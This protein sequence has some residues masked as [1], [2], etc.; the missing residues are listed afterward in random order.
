MIKRIKSALKKIPFVK[1]CVEYRNYGKQYKNIQRELE[2]NNK[3][4][5]GL[6]QELRKANVKLVLKQNCERQQTRKNIQKF[7]EQYGMES[8][9][10]IFSREVIQDIYFKDNPFVSIIILNRNGVD[11]LE[12]LMESFEKSDFYENFEIIF[13]DNASTDA[14]VKYMEKWKATYDI[15]MVCNNENRSFSAA[16]NQAAKIAKGDY[17]LFLNNDVTVTD[18]WLDEMLL[19]MQKVEHP[20][21]IGACLIYP[22]IIED[23]QMK[24]KSYAVQH[25]GI[26]FKDT[27]RQ[28]QYFIRPY[29]I[30]IGD[31]VSD[32]EAAIQERAAV[33]ATAVM[34][35]RY[36]FEAVGG[37]SE[38]Y[39]YGFEDVDLGL[40]LYNMGYKN[41]YCPRC[42]IYHHESEPQGKNRT[43]ETIQR[44]NHNVA[45]FQGKWQKYLSKKI[46]L[47]KLN[48]TRIF[49][50]QLLQI[51]IACDNKSKHNSLTRL[52]KQ[53]EEKGYNVIILNSNS[54]KGYY[55]V[56]PDTDILLI[57]DQDYEI[58]D[59]YNKKND[60]LSIWVK[61]DETTRMDA[62]D[63]YSVFMEELLQDTESLVKIVN[64]YVK[65]K[66]D[67]RMVDIC[68]CMP[69][70]ETKKFWGDWHFANAMKKYF[71]EKGYRANVI[72]KDKWYYRSRA[73]YIIF[74][75]GNA[76]YYPSFEDGK[77]SIMWNISHP[78]DVS[79][80]EYNA[81]D[82]V[83]FA[84]DRLKSDIGTQLH[85]ESGVLIQCTDEQVMRAEEDKEKKYE[86]LFVGNSRHAY[87]QILK[88]L[89]PT[90]YQ[91]T[92]FGRDWEEFQLQQYVLQDYIS[93]DEVGQAYHDAK[94]LLNDH[95]EDMR[96]K[97]IISN[98]IFDAL[99]AG[100]FIISDY[101]PEID[102]FFKG[103][104]VT[105]KDKDDLSQKID[106]YMEHDEER[107]AKARLGQ[108][109]VLKE[110]T[111]R[112]RIAEMIDVMEKL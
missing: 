42:I 64:D 26:A 78:E 34:I 60:L 100:A 106:Y 76:E 80:E 44:E 16:N 82:Y 29:N 9:E 43:E 65:D 63:T 11:K 91:L 24:E 101:M 23:N 103:A 81:Y 55:N 72:T 27:I 87:R 71:G 32:T 110:H 33:A 104:V 20:G 70:D 54:K 19:A 99:A 95:W 31:F 77:V 62:D 89:L 90:K 5:D 48:V 98:R 13:V 30:G 3:K 94:I 46:L 36:A 88:D 40:K 86:L 4:I 68:G 74:L 37:F 107:L 47:D 96:E 105:Y 41:Y 18:G 22:E 14:S 67:E 1:K 8:L 111:F 52:Q 93:N 83:F 109:I 97:G 108:K 58:R 57:L 69:D 50:E 17:L 75:R 56:G 66:I 79:L 112:N 73:K 61:T 49:S 28:K 39:Y 6:L 85:C 53:F 84:S 92:M 7:A 45:V 21:A 2:N 59:I 10:N 38:A 35:D 102:E 15:Q 12:D 25:R 51:A